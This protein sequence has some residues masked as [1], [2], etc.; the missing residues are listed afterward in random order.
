[1]KRSLDLVV[2][3]AAALQ[4][5]PHRRP[6]E[7]VKGRLASTAEYHTKLAPPRPFPTEGKNLICITRKTPLASYLRRCKKVVLEDGYK[8]LHLSAMG[9]AIPHLLQLSV[10]LPAILPFGPNEV[11]TEITTGTVEVQDEIAPDDEDE[12]IEYKTRGK[13]TLLV[14]LKFGDGSGPSKKK[15]QQQTQ[16]GRL[17]LEEPEQ[18]DMEG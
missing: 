18:D 1:M 16:G 15:P 9:A 14:V 12:D 4:A 10:S 11:Q 3:T 5:R 8:T 7:R 13:S 6:S 2:A 17:V